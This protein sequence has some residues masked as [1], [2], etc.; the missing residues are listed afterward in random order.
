V[1]RAAR[2]APPPERVAAILTALEARGFT[3]T[4]TGLSA[5]TGIAEHRIGQVLSG[6]S[7]VLNLDGYPV[8]LIDSA[9]ASVTLNRQLLVEQFGVKGVR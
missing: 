5:A 7:R 8:L 6:L 3:Q 1:E 2:V 4:L 9:A